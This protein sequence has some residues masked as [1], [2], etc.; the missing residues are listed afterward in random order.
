MPRQRSGQ[1]LL[2]GWLPLEWRRHSLPTSTRAPWCRSRRRPA[3][4]PFASPLGGRNGSWRSGPPVPSA[5]FWG[6]RGGKVALCLHMVAVR[7]GHDPAPLPAAEVTLHYRLQRCAGFMLAAM[8][9]S[10]LGINTGAKSKALS[11]RWRLADGARKTRRPK[12]P[13]S[14]IPTDPHVATLRCTAPTP[15]SCW[16]PRLKSKAPL[17]SP[18]MS[19]Q[20]FS[21]IE[22]W[23]S[24]STSRHTSWPRAP[25]GQTLP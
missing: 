2:W 4:C 1:G 23:Q 8:S 15:R 13:L 7:A 10:S 25:R 18:S 12:W 24:R 19:P 9:A 21:R 3:A 17:V 6:N 16:W 11:T 22:A 14:D 20:M 5:P